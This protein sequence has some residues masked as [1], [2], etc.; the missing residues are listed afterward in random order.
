VWEEKNREKLFKRYIDHAHIILIH[1]FFSV[2]RAYIFDCRNRIQNMNVQE[3]RIYPIKSCAGV[4]VQEALITRYGLALP[5]D[6]RI[7]DR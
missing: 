5:S 7:Y 1:I 2:E 6:P 3:L 4:Q